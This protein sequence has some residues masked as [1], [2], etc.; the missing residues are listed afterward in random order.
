[1]LFRSVIQPLQLENKVC[2][3]CKL[4][5]VP[6]VSIQEYCS[7]KCYLKKDHHDNYEGVTITKRRPER[8]MINCH[9]C[10]K[11][12]EPKI[13]NQKFCGKKCY[14]IEWREVHKKPVKVNETTCATASLAVHISPEHDKAIREKLDKIKRTCPAPTKRPEFSRNLG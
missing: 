11:Q 2:P 4:E 8:P 7:R 10:G 14:M 5:F 6:K 12:F 13:N 9:Q 3:E 1:M